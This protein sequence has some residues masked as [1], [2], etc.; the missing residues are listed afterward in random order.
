MTF[1]NYQVEHGLIGIDRKVPSPD[2]MLTMDKSAIVN[3]ICL[4][5]LEV[6]NSNREDYTRD[7]LYDLIV[8]VQSF[9]KQNGKAYKFFEDDE[10]FHIKNT[11]DNRMCALS[12][13]GK[14]SPSIKAVPISAQEENS[15]WQKG[16]LGNDTPVKLVNTLLY[17]LGVHFGLCAADEHKHLKRDGNFSVHYD[18]AVGLK[19]LYYEEKVSKCNQ[20][21]I[22]SRAFSPKSGRAYQ[23]VV[24]SDR[25]VV[26]LY[27]KYISQHPDHDPKCSSDF[28]LRP[29]S[30]PNGDAWYS[31]QARVR[32]LRRCVILGV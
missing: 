1:R 9:L 13:E 27:K 22:A 14:I 32:S 11:L 16:I 10:F 28:Y 17:L 7:T 20:G 4:F 12:K 18:Q 31:C 3:M 5:I 26:R 30:V 21:G 24:N 29:L 25:C 19:Y 8:M 6:K 15:L 23:N 2:E